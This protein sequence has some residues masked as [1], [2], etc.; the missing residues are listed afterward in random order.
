MYLR[1]LL[2]RY[3]IEKVLGDAPPGAP[4]DLAGAVS[5]L[6]QRLKT[7]SLT[8][9]LRRSLEGQLAILRQRID[10]HADADRQVAFIDAEL[11]RIEQQVELIREQAALSTD[12]AALSQRIDE[13]AATLGGTSQWIQD[14]QKVFGAMDDLLTDA[15]PP[16]V[17]RD[18][19]KESS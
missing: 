7:E 3:A 2:A 4:R 12:P 17:R 16:T 13:I 1:L 10:R 19:L 18:R 14:Q 8:D 15:A 5:K 9:E 11:T 6:E